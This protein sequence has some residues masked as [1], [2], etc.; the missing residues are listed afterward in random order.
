MCYVNAT[1]FKRNLS[2][3]MALSEKEDVYVTKNNKVITVLV[4]PQDKALSDFLSFHRELGK[5]KIDESYDDILFQE[6]KTRCGL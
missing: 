4:N 1:E 5:N 6:I 3:Y 2:H